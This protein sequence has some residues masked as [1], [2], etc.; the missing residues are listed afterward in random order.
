MARWVAA[1]RDCSSGI[2]NGR[3][4]GDVA[5]VCQGRPVVYMRGCCAI[6]AATAADAVCQASW[7]CNLVVHRL[8]MCCTSSSKRSMA[9]SS[10]ANGR[11]GRLMGC[12]AC[13][14]Y[15]TLIATGFGS[16]QGGAVGF[17]TYLER[18]APVVID[19]PKPAQAAPARPRENNN[20]IQIPAFLQKRRARGK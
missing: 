16:G 8:P 11:D 20:T 17:P 18:K 3:R 6:N 10:I 19:A 14:V 7:C 12:F 13:Q 2:W 9:S 15:I 4:P 1:L 5:G